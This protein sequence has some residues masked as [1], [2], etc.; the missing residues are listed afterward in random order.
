MVTPSHAWSRRPGKVWAWLWMSTKPGATTRPLDVDGRGALQIVA[1]R[2][3]RT[4]VDPDIAHAVES[5]LRID[6]ATSSQ[7]QVVGHEPICHDRGCNVVTTGVLVGTK[8]IAAVVALAVLGVVAPWGTAAADDGQLIDVGG[9]RHMYLECQG[10]GGPTVVFESGWPND[11]TVWSNGGVFQAVSGFTRACVYDRPGTAT[12]DH[13]SRSDAAPQPRT[14]ADVVADLHAHVARLRR[15]RSVR[16]RRPFDRRPVRPPLRHDVSRTTSPD[17]SS[18]TPATRTRSTSCCRSCRRSWSIPS[19]SARSTRRPTCWP[20]THRSSGSC[21]SRAA[22]R[23]A[24]PRR[25][26]RCRP[27][28]LVV[29]THGIPVSAENPVPPDFPSAG[30]EEILSGPATAP[31][32]PRPGCP[33]GDRRPQR[34][35]HPARGAEPR[36]RRHPRRRRR[37]STRRDAGRRDRAAP[38]RRP[39]TRHHRRGVRRS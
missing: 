37:R 9:G 24:M 25:R 14:A 36:R 23:S 28:P 27:M 13:L 31:R 8:R 35:L 5:G 7:H 10:S 29:L 17:S 18:S 39:A 3:D 32:P 34:P 21:S 22:T 11:G 20:P 12:G 6:D 2:G 15:A 19:C 4:T 38:D 26:R 30:F 1:D 16:P 33:P